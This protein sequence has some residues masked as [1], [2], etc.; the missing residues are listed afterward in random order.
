MTEWSHLANARHIDQVLAH[1]RSFPDR[2]DAKKSLVGLAT[3]YWDV[4]RDVACV[5]ARAE[6]LGAAWGVVRDVV[7]GPAWDASQQVTVDIVLWDATLN[8]ILALVAYD[9]SDRYLTMTAD[10]LAVWG[11]L[12]DD[13]AAILL[14]PYVTLLETVKPPQLTGLMNSAIIDA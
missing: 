4:A 6:A 13:P 3:A 12:S 2:S 5:A 11:A 9:H 14:I 7:S 8:A 1:L 10:H